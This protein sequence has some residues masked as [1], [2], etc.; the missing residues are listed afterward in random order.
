MAIRE[1]CKWEQLGIYLNIKPYK[2]EEIKNE[3]F[4]QIAACRM[5]MVN[6]WIETNTATRDK[7]ISALEGIERNDIVAYVKDLPTN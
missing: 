4:S 6:H 3:N 1:V 5:A 7:L 2:L